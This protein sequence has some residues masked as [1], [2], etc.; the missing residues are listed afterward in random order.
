MIQR[1][2]PSTR[3]VAANYLLL[4]GATGFV[5]RYLLRDLLLAGQRVAVIVRPHRKSSPRRRIEDVMQAW[6]RELGRTLPRPIVLEGDIAQPF[7]G[8]S[9]DDVQ[10]LRQS[11]QRVLH[12][13][14]NLSFF[15]DRQAEPWLTNLDGTRNVVELS[16]RIGVKEFHLLSTAY[17]CGQREGR[18]AENELNCGQGFRND[19]EHSKFQAEQ[20]VRT[21]SKADTVTVYRPA[22]VVGDSR[23]GATTSYQ[24]LF[25]YLRL[26]AMLVPQQQ[27][28]AAGA[29]YTPIH[30][31]MNGDEPRNLVPVDW[32][33]KVVC[34]VI[35]DPTA[36]GKTIHL[37][38]AFRTTPR[39]IVDSCYEYFN[40]CG[41]EYDGPNSPKN[42]HESAF[43][44][45]FFANTK[46]Y[47]DY[48][49]SDPD[50]D[51]SN[52]REHCPHLPCPVVDQAMIHRFLE[53]GKRDQWGRSRAV[54][55]VE[56]V[57]VETA[58]AV[59]AQSDWTD[60]TA[61]PGLD[62]GLDVVGPGG[63][64]WTLSWSAHRGWSVVRGIHSTATHFM[65]LNSTE[66]CSARTPDKGVRWLGRVLAAANFA[67][68]ASAVAINLPK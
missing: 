40:S 1:I 19:Y 43:A 36:H 59:A 46:I 41:V 18:I 31:P 5:G 11:C 68:S 56:P 64:Q 55:I 52:L 63:G 65:Q 47:Q 49:R 9:N 13:A 26:L 16:D 2:Y 33:S 61:A 3:K 32:V 51:C 17:V 37:A 58:L 28:N 23:T 25:L 60:L 44:K 38:P 66:L 8:L 22:V 15:G 6:E 62:L 50:F 54:P 34:T 4:T 45:A 20:Y 48:E 57:D 14:A 12:A 7:L 21:F 30:L 10:W 42:E 39:S 24:G 67:A 29:H 35:D 53:F 27:R